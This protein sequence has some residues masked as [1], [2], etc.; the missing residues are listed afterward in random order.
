LTVFGEPIVGRSL[1]V[2]VADAPANTAVALI[3]G[4]WSPGLLQ[5]ANGCVQ[6]LD[7]PFYTTSSVLDHAG[8]A[9]WNVD[10]PIEMSWVH[11]DALA[12]QAAVFGANTPLLTNAVRA[13]LGGGL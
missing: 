9:R 2:Q 13:V 11:S 3:F 12:M 1:Q 7:Q 4:S 5:L 10:L 8:F 6:H